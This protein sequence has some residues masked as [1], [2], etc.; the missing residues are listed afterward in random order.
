MSGGGIKPNTRPEK[1]RGMNRGGG[2]DTP[3]RLLLYPFLGLDGARRG[4]IF[5]SFLVL[6]FE[7][8]M[9][10]LLPGMGR[11]CAVFFFPTVLFGL[12]ACILLL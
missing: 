10:F 2:G 11:R 9:F 8:Y 7:L 3:L 1:L 6:F 12:G 5:F 4:A